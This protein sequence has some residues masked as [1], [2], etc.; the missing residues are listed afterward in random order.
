MFL[1]LLSQTPPLLYQ[2]LGGLA[3]KVRAANQENRKVRAQY[4]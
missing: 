2:V 1:K 4:S 3:E